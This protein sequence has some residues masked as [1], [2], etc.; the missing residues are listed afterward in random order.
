[1][2]WLKFDVFVGYSCAA[3]IKISSL[4]L[5][6]SGFAR[7]VLSCLVLVLRVPFVFT[8]KGSVLL[9]K[10]WCGYLLMEL[11]RI[12]DRTIHFNHSWSRYGKLNLPTLLLSASYMLLLLRG[13]KESKCVTRIF[14][15]L[16]VALHCSRWI[17]QF[18]VSGL[19]E[20]RSSV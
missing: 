7:R 20:G 16:N 19:A 1:M 18:Y 15:C 10:D 14:T 13:V 17:S 6:L 4:V 11:W 8:K 9:Q 2:S 5:W 3:F 12:M